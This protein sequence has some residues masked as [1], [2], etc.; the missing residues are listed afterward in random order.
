MHHTDNIVV[1]ITG[2]IAAYKS[3]EL[4]R[5][6]QK[7]GNDVKVVM[8]ENA[9]RFVGK[10]TFESITGHPVISEMFN[11]NARS[12]E[13]RHTALADWVDTV[14]VA[15]ATA[16][17]I[18]KYVNGIADD[19]LSTFLMATDKPVV[20]APAM[21]PRM[22]QSRAMQRNL[23]IL[24]EWGVTLVGPDTGIVACGHEGPGKMSQPEIIADWV[25]SVAGSQRDLSGCRVLV[26]AGP[27]REMIDPV[28]F[29]SNRSTGKMG[30]AI[31]EAAVERG[32]DVT[33][34]TGPVN[35]RHHAAVKRINVTSAQEMSEE[36]GSRFA[37]CDVLVMA[38]AVADLK[39]Q[40][41]L[42]QK[43]KK[44]SEDQ[45]LSLVRTSDIL[46]TLSTVRTDDQI[47]VGFAAETENVLENARLK[48]QAKKLDAIV[49]NDVGQEGAG[50]EVDTNIATMIL[51]DSTTVS[52]P[53][54]QK[55]EMAD[56]IW[57]IIQTLPNR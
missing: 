29:I 36:V 8:T 49:V 7:S 20:I 40:K 44:T 18:G 32:A 55:R 46:K 12:H 50:F 48:I 22:Y 57:D 54:S 21:N 23:T 3:I 11:V 45:S 1:G 56:K 5:S 30:F 53:L 25:R 47:V 52:L 37:D 13:I 38:A 14:V 27:T 34:V 17:I 28:R 39:P 35:Q 51:K 16:N 31:A 41:M 43:W 10:T 4:I 26:T 2:G 24:Q 6:L 19:F 9:T 33:L 15:P 42:P